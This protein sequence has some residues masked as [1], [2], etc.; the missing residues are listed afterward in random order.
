MTTIL[1]FKQDRALGR[2]KNLPEGILEWLVEH[3]ECELL[4][5]TPM[6]GYHI[7]T[8]REDESATEF[9]LRFRNSFPI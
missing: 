7:F 3:P 1:K 6:P 4:F 2:V 9:K 5:P 8:F